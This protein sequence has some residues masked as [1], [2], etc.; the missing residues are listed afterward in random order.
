MSGDSGGNPMAAIS[1][2][3]NVQ[4]QTP[5]WMNG[6]KP[7]TMPQAMPGQLQA[8]AAQLAGGFGGVKPGE[9]MKD[10]DRTYDPMQSMNF[11]ASNALANK[12]TKTAPAKPMDPWAPIPQPDGSTK[13]AWMT[14][15]VKQTGMPRKPPGR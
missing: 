12:N 4:A 8:I 7:Q 10:L 9:M 1:Q 15:L 2:A 14:G 6:V 3:N 11:T 13:P 5:P